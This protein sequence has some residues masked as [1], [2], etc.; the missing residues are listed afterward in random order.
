MHTELYRGLP[1]LRY[2]GGVRSGSAAVERRGAGCLA[3]LVCG[4]SMLLAP[5]SA[6]ADD[7]FDFELGL[8]LDLGAIAGLDPES[9]EMGVGNSANAEILV[10]PH[11]V[12]SVAVGA[13]M[14]A[15][16]GQGPVGWFGTRAGLRFHWGSLIDGFEPDAWIQVTHLFGLSGPI[17][18]H[19]V[20]IG[21]GL[22]FFL[23][24]AMSAGPTIHLIY[25]DDPDGTPVWMLIAG[26][27]V[28]GWPGR[29]DTGAPEAYVSPARRRRRYVAPTN[30]ELARR[31]ERQAAPIGLLP[32]V[33]LLGLHALDDAHRD[34][35]GFGGGASAAVEFPIQPW[36]GVQ[37]GVTG[38]AV[39]ASTGN[40]ASWA[41][42]ELGVR[43]HWTAAAGLEGDGW[44]DANWVYGTSSNIA[45]H[46]ASAALGY[47]FDVA[48]FLRLGP[49][50]RGFMLTDPGTDPA[51]I[52]A[53]G[54]EVAIRAPE[55]GPGNRD[56]DFL[57][58]RED[59]CLD[60]E[61]GR[62]E[63]PNN[64]G[65]PLLDRDG[66]GVADNRDM[67]DTEPEG[68]YPDP[69]R[70]GCPLPDRDGDAIPDRMDFCPDTRVT[71]DDENADPLRD[72][73]PRGVQ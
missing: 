23:F 17:A 49:V 13:H 21:L 42:T 18:R 32:H 11:P 59:A 46:G 54:L 26:L 10:R 36:I 5:A 4:L 24:D 20:D 39:S 64:P 31:Q 15:L 66:D 72:G 61:G 29:P 41:G 60:T 35:I 30:L 37:A 3:A 73:C 44:I 12:V 38:M 7:D 1:H 8:N 58:D 19:G 55:R 14:F 43:F 34:S 53:A 50:V 9:N 40:P 22:G 65:C 33:E 25:T 71:V 6:L 27:T 48:S 28:T 2:R 69:D 52:L 67:C 57:L 63:D 45:T 62:V 56:G 68:A 70:R 16:Y 47:S 51:W